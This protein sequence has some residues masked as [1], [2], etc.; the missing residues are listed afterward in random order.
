MK[1][2]KLFIETDATMVEINPLAEASN[3]DGELWKHQSALPIVWERW[4]EFSHSNKDSRVGNGRVGNEE[5]NFPLHGCPHP[6]T[7]RRLGIR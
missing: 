4:Y 6:D 5:N 3:H 1:L 2:Y 7:Q